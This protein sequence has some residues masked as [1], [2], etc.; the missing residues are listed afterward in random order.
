MEGMRNAFKI[1]IGKAE[2]KNSLGKLRHKWEDN[3]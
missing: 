1:L 3:I 2:G